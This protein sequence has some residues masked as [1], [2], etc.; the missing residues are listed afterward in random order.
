M[1]VEEISTTVA[2]AYIP[3]IWVK[4]VAD[5][6]L[7][8]QGLH[9]TVMDYSPLVK[10]KKHGDVFHIPSFG[11]L[12]AEAIDTAALPHEPQSNTNVDNS[13]PMDKFY[14]VPLLIPDIVEVQSEELLF[15]EYVKHAAD[16]LM[17][18]AESDLSVT[19]QSGTTNDADLTADNTCTDTELR[20]AIGKLKTYK[21]DWPKDCTIGVNPLIWAK[22]LGEEFNQYQITGQ[23]Y[24]TSLQPYGA[25]CIGSTL[26]G[27]D[28]GA[29]TEAMTL[30][31]KS[32]VA[33]A[34]QLDPKVMAQTAPLS[35][36]TELSVST[37]YGS[38]MLFE[39]RTA[40]YDQV[41]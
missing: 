41:D 7:D 8:Y 10:G 38:V 26:W 5:Y 11:A 6:L 3:E 34:M 29:A 39:E 20:A 25:T 14:G 40:N 27:Q 17:Y 13:L 36:G 1:A 33:F 2:A 35:Y 30:W 21:V 37:I 4:G 22:W 9:N 12:T 18:Q 24:S 16:C 19:L 31:H 32:A 23:P 15:N 28:S